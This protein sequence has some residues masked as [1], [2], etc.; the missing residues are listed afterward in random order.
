[1]LALV[2]SEWVSHGPVRQVEKAT[3]PGSAALTPAL[4]SERSIAVLPFVDLSEKKDQEYF[5]EGIAEEIINLLVKVPN[6]KVVGRASSFSYKGRGDDWRAIAAGLGAAYVAEGSVRRSGDHVR[7]TAQ[8]I[9]TRDG[10]H[11]WSE[12]YDR[13]VNDV[14]QVQAEIAASLVRGLQLEVAPS[15]L[16]QWAASTHKSEAYDLYLRAQHA[17]YRFDERGLQEAEADLHRALDIDSAFVPAAETLAATE[18]DLAEMGYV[19]PTTGYERARAAAVAALKLEPKSGLAHAVLGAVQFQY[20]WDWSAAEAEFKIAAALAPRNPFVLIEA[21][22]ERTSVGDWSGAL[23]YLNSVNSADP[24]DAATY[25]ALSN[26]YM[27]LDRP[28]ETESAARRALE[29]SPTYSGAHGVLGEILL[30]EGRVGDAMSEFRIDNPNETP[31]PHLVAAYWAE[32]RM[33]E[34]DAILARLMLLPRDATSPTAVAG[35]F[36]YRGEKRRALA[37]LEQAYARH[38]SRLYWIRGELLLRN[39]EGESEYAAILR[40]MKLLQ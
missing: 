32:H 17:I 24:L 15:L 30:L 28:A 11:R 39:V 38:D 9:D 27:H 4:I 40:K 7:I 33:K 25:T 29:I 13:A 31:T 19:P 21:A 2:S 8:L 34:S 26:V 3:A 16:S 20:D 12:T 18:F 36:A 5:A 14:L 1:V 22:T 37:R 10:A 35:A 6:L 23:Q